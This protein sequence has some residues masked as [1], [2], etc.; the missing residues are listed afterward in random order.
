MPEK[1]RPESADLEDYEVL[2]SGDTLSGAPGDDPLD[3]GVVPPE[4]WSAGVRFGTTGTEQE[5]GES[6][7][8]LLAEEEPDPALDFTD[9]EP[10]DIEDVELDEDAGDED[11][12]G[13]LLDDGPD[14]RAGRLVQEDEGAHPDEEEDLVASDV[15]IDGGGATAEEAAMHVVDEDDYDVRSE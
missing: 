6:L 1:D 5:E 9:D 12:D 10:E 8:Q 7:D 13:L 3:R 4:R 14:P 2:D 11:V 15:G